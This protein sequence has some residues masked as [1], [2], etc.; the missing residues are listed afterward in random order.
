M[1][2]N[3]I[4]FCTL[5]GSG[6][7]ELLHPST[8]PEARRATLSPDEFLC[9]GIRYGEHDDILRCDSC[10]F[11]FSDSPFTPEQLLDAYSQV[12]DERYTRE[13]PA[14][15]A[16]FRRSMDLI[17]RHAERGRVLDVGCYTGFFLEVCRNRGWEVA[18]VEPSHWAVERARSRGLDIF[19]GSLHEA[20]FPEKHFD[21]I[22]LWDVLEHFPNPREAVRLV[23]RLLRPGGRLF[24]TTFDI[25]SR[26]ARLL[27]PRY[28]MLARAHVSYFSTETLGGL[29]E[30][31]G[32]A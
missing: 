31:E 2:D 8:V 21:L 14:R 6:D 24:L 10:G 12:V 13:R 19:R 9:T 18:G 4:L 5:C 26:P 16:T 17:G 27:G 28:P 32:F 3:R 15:M 29:L 30:S 11:V 7:T 23:N 22:T 25:S 20:D 1:N